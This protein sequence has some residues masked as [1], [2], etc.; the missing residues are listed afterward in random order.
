MHLE[1]TGRTTEIE[2]SFILEPVAYKLRNKG[3][4]IGSITRNS[5]EEWQLFTCEMTLITSGTLEHCKKFFQETKE[6]N[7]AEQ[8]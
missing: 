7:N 5:Y 8:D 4:I 1:D 6:V 3:K 2:N